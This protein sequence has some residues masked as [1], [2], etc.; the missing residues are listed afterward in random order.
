VSAL[1]ALAICAVVVWALAAPFRGRR[2]ARTSPPGGTAAPA[3]EPGPAASDRP[4]GD[5]PPPAAPSAD[6]HADLR[7]E[8]ERLLAAIADL[9]FDFEAGKLSRTDY[10][11]E[12]AQLR[13]RAAEVL[14]ILDGA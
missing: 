2:D 1:L 9:R 13:R 12:D 5:G 7:E 10:E 3:A 14:R 4:P 11:M 8:R 6:G